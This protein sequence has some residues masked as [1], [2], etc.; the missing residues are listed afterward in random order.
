MGRGP[1][2]TTIMKL[3]DYLDTISG[4]EAA[5]EQL[6]KAYTDGTAKDYLAGQGW[7]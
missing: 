2:R 4:N 7:S 5:S 6:T 1:E 3:T